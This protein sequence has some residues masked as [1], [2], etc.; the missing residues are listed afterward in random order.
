MVILKAMVQVGFLTQKKASL[1]ANERSH[2]LLLSEMLLSHA[3][4]AAGLLSPQPQAPE[5][6]HCS[7]QY[8]LTLA[9]SSQSARTCQQSV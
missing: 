8:L 9:F 2:S 6:Q 1:T 4:E 5:M 7:L 3:T